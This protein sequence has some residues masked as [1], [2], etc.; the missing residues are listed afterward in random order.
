MEHSSLVDPGMASG[1][2]LDLA[3][4]LGLMIIF[5]LFSLLD[6]GSSS[7]CTISLMRM[8]RL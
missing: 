3:G 5:S 6:M 7:I 4:T 2:S 1:V 8:D